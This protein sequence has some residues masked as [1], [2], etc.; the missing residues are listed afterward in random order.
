MFEIIK[1]G[2]NINFMGSR[3][4]AFMF[5]GT[6]VGLSL[7]I[8]I[9]NMFMPGRGTMLNYGLDFLGGTQIQ[10][11][12]DRKVA[13][14]D[15]R[16]ALEKIG[17]KD[18]SVSAMGKTGYMVSMRSFSS[19]TDDQRAAIEKSFMDKYKSDLFRIRFSAAGDHIKVRFHGPVKMDEFEALFVALNLKARVPQAELTPE[20]IDYITRVAKGETPK[21]DKPMPAELDYAETL[22]VSPKRNE[23]TIL[24]ESVSEKIEEGLFK[25]LGAKASVLSV[26]SR[27]PQVGKRLRIQGILSLLYALGFILLYIVLRFDLKFAPGAI[28]ALIHD[29]LI[30]VG[31]FALFW[32]EFSLPILAALLTIVGYSLNDTIVVYDRIRENILKLRSHSLTKVVNTSINETLSRTILTSATTFFTVAA[33]FVVADGVLRDFA[34]AMGIG[35]I[36]GTY[37]SIFVASPM[38]IFVENTFGRYFVADSRQEAEPMDEDEEE[39]GDEG[40]DDDANEGKPD[41]ELTEEELKERDLRKAKRLRRKSRG[42]RGGKRKG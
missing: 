2:I 25:A 26:E 13:P 9:G 34:L 4:K 27:G 33:I 18:A 17:Y 6:L 3:K 8:L 5:S 36:V 29:V 32:R 20:A 12:F 30:T 38:V 10:L 24:L 21:W 37:S 14:G 42:G 39:E 1:P 7:L 41:E 28:V 40:E 16:V 22:T 15:L 23:Y 11:E 35:I 31:I 19:I